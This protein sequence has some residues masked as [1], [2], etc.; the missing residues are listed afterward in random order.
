MI[1]EINSTK[2]LYG[3]SAL[4]DLNEKVETLEKENQK[5]RDTLA[6]ARSFIEIY[7]RD[8]APPLTDAEAAMIKPL[9]PLIENSI[10]DC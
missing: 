5:L 2:K 3:S 4:R 7:F 10:N 9:L 1:V 8:I 6:I